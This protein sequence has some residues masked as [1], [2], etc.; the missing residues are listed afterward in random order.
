MLQV[1]QQLLS[2]GATVEA[3]D[4]EGWR[5]LHW[6]SQNGHDR[7]VQL[8]LQAGATAE[9]HDKN[10]ELAAEAAAAAP[11]AAEIALL[12]TI[13]KQLGMYNQC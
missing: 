13:N 1:V 9:V 2:A 3:P 12:C 7:V 10:G 6:A 5:P 11:A 8:L 4:T